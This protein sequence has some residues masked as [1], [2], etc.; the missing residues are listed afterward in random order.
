MAEPSGTQNSCVQLSPG[1]CTLPQRRL[2]PSSSMNHMRAST[3]SCGPSW[4]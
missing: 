3:R 2:L 1:R 4:Q